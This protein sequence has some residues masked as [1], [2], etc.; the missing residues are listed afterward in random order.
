MQTFWTFIFFK[1]SWKENLNIS[2]IFTIIPLFIRATRIYWTVCIA[3]FYWSAVWSPE[4]IV[5]KVHSVHQIRV[6]TIALI[7]TTT[8]AKKTESKIP[9]VPSY[10]SKP[11]R[12]IFWP[13]LGAVA[14]Y[15]LK[16]LFN[17]L[18]DLKLLPALWIEEIKKYTLAYYLQ[19]DCY[20]CF[21]GK[22]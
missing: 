17:K 11:P 5:T 9:S 13:G 14:R 15:P 16:F 1:L 21:V 4:I 20:C 6:R 8:Y 19:I 22:H 12:V 10:S 18:K 3:D 2:N 7:G